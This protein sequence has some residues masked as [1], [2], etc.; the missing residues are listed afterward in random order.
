MIRKYIFASF[1]AIL[2]CSLS[3]FAK[4]NVET[5]NVDVAISNDGSAYI[6]Q[7]WTGTF[8]QGTEN[9]IPIENLDGIT[10]S[11]FSVSDTENGEYE[12][13][14]FWNVDSSFDEKAGKCGIVETARGYELCFGITEYGYNT[15]IISYKL[16]G[17][18]CGYSDYDGFNFMF[19]NSGMS[20]FPTQGSINIYM[21]DGTELNENNSRIWGFGYEGGIYLIDGGVYA[22]TE[23]ELSG[24]DCMIV[25][26]QLD[27]GIVTP[28]RH[29]EDSFE[30]VKNR[31]FEGSDYQ[32]DSDDEIIG[33]IFCGGIFIAFV[34]FVKHAIKV[35]IQNAKYKKFYKNCNYFRDVPNDG[36]M[37]L[38][39]FLAKKFGMSKEDSIIN[40]CI[41][42][43]IVGGNLSSKITEEPGMFGK[44]SK[45][46]ELT[47][48]SEPTEEMLSKL[49]NILKKSAGRDGILQEREMDDYFYN[50]YEIIKDFINDAGNDGEQSLIKLG[51]CKANKKHLNYFDDLSENGRNALQENAGLRKYLS[52]F[53]LISER[54]LSES[55]I[56]K[57]Y[58]VYAVLYGIGDKV[59]EQIKKLYPNGIPKEYDFEESLYVAMCCRRCTYGAMTKREAAMRA[60]GLGGSSSH[61][62]GGGF[63]GGGSG[64][65]SR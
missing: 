15:Y 35:A 62:G 12:Y 36:N 33:L 46:I 41:L 19:I 44:I 23:Q 2:A 22:Y 30:D 6:I 45:K 13:I 50:H 5:I 53:S 28:L 38:S 17:I 37:A 49:Y 64:G 8:E 57:D 56:W 51:G 20:T 60:E 61:F 24:S 40:S 54:E 25:M 31:A 34:L 58:M 48:I 18:V 55:A 14:N 63:S 32:T 43:M 27:K 9:Y 65:G 4:N 52:E 7:E 21:L 11:D 39:Y 26:L 1:F 16:N 42:K 47:L 29:S 10:I 3:V 59:I